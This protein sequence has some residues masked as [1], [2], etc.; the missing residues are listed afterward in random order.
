M[1]RLRASGP[2]PALV[3]AILA[4]VAGVSGAAVADPVA[5]KVTTK[6]VKKIANKQIEKKA[7]G[8]SVKN[9]DNLG[10]VPA[11]EYQA[12]VRWA[13]VN[14]GTGAILAQSG[15]VTLETGIAGF[16]YLNW[17]EN[18]GSRALQVSVADGSAGYVSGQPCGAAPGAGA[19][20]PAFNDVNHTLVKMFNSTPAPANLTY[21]ISVA[22]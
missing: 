13:L 19:C 14:A 1:R 22:E 5:K 11:D 6:K 12:R 10:G 8:L 16:S 21:F 20:N 4:L 18:I 17:G 15:G 7:P 3:V 9:A 2:T